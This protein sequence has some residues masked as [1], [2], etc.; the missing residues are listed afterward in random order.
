MED[1]KVSLKEILKAIKDFYRILDMRDLL[2]IL[3]ILVMLLMYM[4]H[5]RELEACVEFYEAI[6]ENHTTY[7]YF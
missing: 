3:L 5:T 6:L 2:F 7:V 4:Y 1:D